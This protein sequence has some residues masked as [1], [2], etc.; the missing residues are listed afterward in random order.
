MF[1]R[2]GVGADHGL[3]GG[4]TRHTAAA[5]DAQ[6]AAQILGVGDLTLERVRAAID[7]IDLLLR[8]RPRE[9]VTVRVCDLSGEA[10]HLRI[11]VDAVIAES[12]VARDDDIALGQACVLQMPGEHRLVDRAQIDRAHRRG[13]DRD[14][15]DPKHGG[16]RGG[17]PANRAQR[18]PQDE[19]TRFS[20]HASLVLKPK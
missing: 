1:S 13:K 2:G 9:Q 19:H 12:A 6:V 20:R 8:Q 10:P 18:E 7:D 14:D 4:V 3:A 5:D 11:P 15:R 17:A 16:R